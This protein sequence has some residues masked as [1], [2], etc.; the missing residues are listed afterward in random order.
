MESFPE[1]LILAAGLSSRMGEQKLLLDVGGVPM[2]VGV[3]RAAMTSSLRRLVVVLGRSSTDLVDALGHLSRD[4]RLTVTVNRNPEHG[5]SSSLRAGIASITPSAA[6][7]MIV[8]G[9]QPFLTSDVIDRLID[10][11]R[12]DP[13]KIVV[14]CV[15]GRRSNPVIFPADLLPDLTRTRGDVGGRFVLKRNA[16]RIVRIEMGDRYDDSDVDTPEDL[17]RLTQKVRRESKK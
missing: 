1:G 5:M 3:V 7:V 11:F 9:D 10:A 8:L 4:P 6:G 2:L 15:M 12:A 13:G 14:P 16:D 17:Q